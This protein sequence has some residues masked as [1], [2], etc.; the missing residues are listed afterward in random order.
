MDKNKGRVFDE[1]VEYALEY[2]D[3]AMGLED[4]SDSLMLFIDYARMHLSLI[5]I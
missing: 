1:V 3:W 4:L 5:H 2:C